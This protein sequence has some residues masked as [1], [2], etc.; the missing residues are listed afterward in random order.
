MRKGLLLFFKRNMNGLFKYKEIF[1]HGREKSE[2]FIKFHERKPLSG[3]MVC[4]WVFVRLQGCVRNV[5]YVGLWDY[6]FASWLPSPGKK[7]IPVLFNELDD[8]DCNFDRNLTKGSDILNFICDWVVLFVCKS[9]LARPFSVPA[10][11]GFLFLYCRLF[12]SLIVHLLV[13]KGRMG[14]VRAINFMA[15]NI[16]S[17]ISRD[18]SIICLHVNLVVSYFVGEFNAA[19]KGWVLH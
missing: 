19:R 9:M 4:L 2:L 5:R 18:C 8:D 17:Q 7:H 14:G 10:W 11:I 1:E 16:S 15:I 12:W 13:S 6:V 3:Y